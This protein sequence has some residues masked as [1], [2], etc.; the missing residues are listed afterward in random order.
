MAPAYSGNRA[1]YLLASPDQ[2]LQP[3]GYYL[4]KIRQEGTRSNSNGL[5]RQ[6]R[7]LKCPEIKRKRPQLNVPYDRPLK[8]KGLAKGQTKIR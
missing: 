5:I 4:A 7:D 6:I 8:R 3:L 2:T 1:T